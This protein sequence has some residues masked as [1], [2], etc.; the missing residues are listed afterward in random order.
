[1]M[2]MA[3]IVKFLLSLFELFCCHLNNVDDALL[4]PVIINFLKRKIFTTIHLNKHWLHNSNIERTFSIE[5]LK[6]F[7]SYAQ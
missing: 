5:H 4:I 6:F 1:M 3:D 2:S 7:P